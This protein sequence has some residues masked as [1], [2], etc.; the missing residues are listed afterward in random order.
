MS[1]GRVVG[2]VF[3]VE[4]RCFRVVLWFR[5][6]ERVARDIDPSSDDNTWVG[7]FGF[8]YGRVE[9]VR[10]PGPPRWPLLEVVDAHG[11]CIGHVGQGDSVCDALGIQVHIDRV[12]LWTG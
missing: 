2:R 8:H 6:R 1:H 3:R 10:V 11:H 12:R 7:P 4:E 5:G 9:E